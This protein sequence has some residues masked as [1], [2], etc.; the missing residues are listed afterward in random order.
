[1]YLYFSFYTPRSSCSNRV[2]LNLDY[3]T[4]TFISRLL[5]K[6]FFNI[7]NFENK[8]QRNSKSNILFIEI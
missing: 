2:W 6:M 7:L 1:M 4:M 8:L 3:W 5:W